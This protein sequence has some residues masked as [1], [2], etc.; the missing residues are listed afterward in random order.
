L[1]VRDALRA[2]IREAMGAPRDD[3]AIAVLDRALER[4]RVR[5]AFGAGDDADF[6]VDARGV[7]GAVGRLLASAV[8]ADLDGRWQRFRICG[9]T[10]CG[11]VF[12][13]HSRNR[14]GKWCSMAVCGNRAKVRAFRERNATR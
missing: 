5:P 9:D 7:V 2:R 12:Y 4:A 1:E 8:V 13:D 14:S 3:H 11:E 6:L 10:T